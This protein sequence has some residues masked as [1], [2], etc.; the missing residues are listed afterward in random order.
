MPYRSLP[1]PVPTGTG[2]GPGSICIIIASV[3]FSYSYLNTGFASSQR[4]G[5]PRPGLPDARYHS[6]RLQHNRFEYEHEDEGY[7][8]PSVTHMG[9]GRRDD[10]SANGAGGDYFAPGPAP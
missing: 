9:P 6:A 10:T 1:P 5:S 8:N 4:V 2:G 7:A 3:L